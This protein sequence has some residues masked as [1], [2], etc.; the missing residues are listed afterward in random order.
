MYFV[1]VCV[2]VVNVMMR[3]PV[4]VSI[5]KCDIISLIITTKVMFD[6][7]FRKINCFFENSS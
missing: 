7:I 4:N 6:D 1:V 2:R 3:K 5:N